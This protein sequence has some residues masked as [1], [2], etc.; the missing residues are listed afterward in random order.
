MAAVTGRRFETEPATLFGYA[1]ELLSGRDYPGLFESPND[2][3]SG[4]LHLGVDDDSV[5]LLDVFEGAL[6]AKRVVAV[7]ANDGSRRSAAVYV[8]RDEHR[9][10][11]T[12]T[13]WER[14]RFE[15]KW[16]FRMPPSRRR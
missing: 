15:P 11:I 16:R 1:R 7:T 2:S 3:T 14:S 13:P 8:L 12:G 5:A 4:T 9:G 10:L 6:Y